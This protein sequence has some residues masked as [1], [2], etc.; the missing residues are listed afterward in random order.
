MASQPDLLFVAVNVRVRAVNGLMTPRR[1]DRPAVRFAGRGGVQQSRRPR[2]EGRLYSL[3][4]FIL[5]PLGREALP[6][7]P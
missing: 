7:E 5:R 2:H 6:F 3:W 4:P 1:A